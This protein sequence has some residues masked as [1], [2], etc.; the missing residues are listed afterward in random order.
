MKLTQI[1]GVCWA[2]RR[3]FVFVLAGTVG[4][5]TAFSLLKHKTY[6]AEVEVMVDAKNTDPVTGSA[7][8][9]QMQS[10]I[11]ATQA[12]V[13]SSRNVALKVVDRLRLAAD[14]ATQRDFAEDDDAGTGSIRDWLADRLLSKLTVRSSRDSNV[15]SVSFEARDPKQA[16]RVANAFA[17][18]YIQTSIDLRSDP[19]KRQAIWFDDQ[20]QGLRQSLQNA[21][22]RLSDYQQKR[23]IVGTDDRLDVEN[24]KLNELANQLVIAQTAMYDAE[25]RQKQMTKALQDN[26]LEELPDVLGNGLLQSMKSDLV[27]AE[28]HLA[29]VAQRYD[30]NHPANVSAAA[31]VQTLRNKLAAELGT[32]KGS[33][34]QAAQLAQQRAAESQRALDAQKQKILELKGQR[35][36]LDVLNREVE[37]AQHAYDAAMQRTSE[38]RLTGRLDQTNIAVLN[39]ATPPTKPAGPKVLRNIVLSILAGTILAL[40]AALGLEL[41]DRRVRSSA[42]LLDLEGVV[43]LAEIPGL[44]L[45]KPKP[46]RAL[47]RRG[48]AA[49]APTVQPAV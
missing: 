26:R 23:K 7:L 10:N 46:A 13:I 22:E 30:K 19:A 49:T 48:P 16:A 41:L 31:E 29:E 36:G 43:V 18:S 25:S 37:N 47:P 33:I 34:N 12:D 9:Q 45:S 20:L 32:V 4:A 1:F 8:P 38:L 39:P 14:P 28:G 24:S 44:S 2:R 17:D 3:L 21:Q 11:Q 27:R 42:D 6:L 15:I 40:G 35:D 5:A